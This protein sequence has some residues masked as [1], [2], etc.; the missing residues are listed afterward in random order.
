MK[1]YRRVLDKISCGYDVFYLIF[2]VAMCQ[3]TG[4][5]HAGRWIDDIQKGDIKLRNH[6]LLVSKPSLTP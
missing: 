3:L 4:V 1:L 6:C 5:L 2:S